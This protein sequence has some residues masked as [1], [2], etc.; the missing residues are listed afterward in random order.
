M[1]IPMGRKLKALLPKVSFDALGLSPLLRNREN[2]WFRV[3]RLF[4]VD[5]APNMYKTRSIWASELISELE[6]IGLTVFVDLD[7]K[8]K[9]MLRLINSIKS[10]E[11][12]GL[13]YLK[14]CF[15]QMLARLGITLL[16]NP[17]LKLH[18]ISFF[19]STQKRL[20]KAEF[21]Y[22]KDIQSYKNVFK[23]KTGVVVN[24]CH[25]VKGEEFH[26]VI[27]FG[28]LHGY[29]PNWS[30]ADENDAARK[31]LYVICSRAK[32]QLYLISENGRKTMGKKKPYETTGV[33]AKV[34]YKYD[35]LKKSD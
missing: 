2:I 18:W 25:G 22:A 4:L 10:D 35:S 8:N 3:A 33:L 13:D 23:H 9:M 29:I 30:E 24:T 21:D 5:P 17:T 12:N 28:L 32:Q 26:T 27:A 31:L 1:V 6:S 19:E 14:D 15:E 20:D 11:E 7:G 16:S 34:S